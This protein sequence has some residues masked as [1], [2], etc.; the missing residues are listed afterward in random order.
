MRKL[1]MATISFSFL[2]SGS[3]F[4]QAP[5][6]I[7]RTSY[8]YAFATPGVVAGNGTSPTINIGAGAEGLIKDGL[9][10]SADLSYLSFPRS[11]FRDGFGMFS[12]G[13][14]YQYKTSGKTVPSVYE[15]DC[16][17]ERFA[18]GASSSNQG[19]QICLARGQT[20]RR[21]EARIEVS[22]S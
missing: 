10:V 16:A 14:I 22:E 19:M 3:S 13:I 12:P 7:P 11:G 2:L 4:G 9:G 1:L 8:G 20:K 5:E 6:A 17:A 15:T 18:F 21:V